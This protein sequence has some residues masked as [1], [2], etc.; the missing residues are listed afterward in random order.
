MSLP[1]SWSKNKSSKKSAWKQVASGGLCVSPAFTQTSCSAYSSTL[2]MEATCSS[3]TLVD[4]QRTACRNIPECITLHNH[5]C[6]NIKSYISMLF[7]GSIR[8]KFVAEFQL[9]WIRIF[10]IFLRICQENAILVSSGGL[11]FFSFK[12]LDY[13]QLY[14]KIHAFAALEK[15]Q[16]RISLT[17]NCSNCLAWNEVDHAW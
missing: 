7:L 10:M 12:I 13:T 16:E 15:S 2:K 4:F 17:F 6:E 9:F 5:R 14:P 1:S 8:F 11:W 3:E